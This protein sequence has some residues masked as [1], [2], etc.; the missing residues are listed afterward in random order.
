MSLVFIGVG[1]GRGGRVGRGRETGVGLVIGV[2]VAVGVGDGVA[3]GAGL[4]V[5]DCAQ[6][7]PPVFVTIGGVVATSGNLLG[8]WTPCATSPPHTIILLP[9]HTAV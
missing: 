4:G 6:Y 1:Y 3:L 2:G 7:L 5:A 8:W 9:V